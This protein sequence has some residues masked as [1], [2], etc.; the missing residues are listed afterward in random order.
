M[1]QQYQLP[2]SF[3]IEKLSAIHFLLNSRRSFWFWLSFWTP[4][5]SFPMPYGGSV[6]TRSA[7]CPSVAFWTSLIFRL[8]PQ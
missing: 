8:S 1:P 6:K 4:S 7:R 5:L 3:R 2:F